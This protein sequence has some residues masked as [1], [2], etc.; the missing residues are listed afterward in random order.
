MRLKGTQYTRNNLGPKGLRKTF[1]EH[2]TLLLGFLALLH[3]FLTTFF[4][5]AFSLIQKL[6]AF[7]ALS[8]APTYD[9]LVLFFFAFS[10][11]P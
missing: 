5:K 4:E 1:S 8:D 3:L 7:R 2:E 10:L 11:T 6:C 9:V